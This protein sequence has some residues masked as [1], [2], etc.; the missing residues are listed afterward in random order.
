M[1]GRSEAF[2]LGGGGRGGGGVAT[3][4]M[5]TCQD[6]LQG[7][8]KDAGNRKQETDRWLNFLLSTFLRCHMVSSRIKALVLGGGGEIKAREVKLRGR[9]PTACLNT[10]KTI[11]F[12]MGGAPLNM[13][14]NNNVVVGGGA[15]WIKALTGVAR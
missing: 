1:F 15:D 14:F 11:D 8:T 2:P 6:A 4:E 12:I 5:V 3:A 9:P 13:H 7:R 10:S